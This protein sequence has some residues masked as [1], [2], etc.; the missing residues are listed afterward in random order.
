M[1]LPKGI[2][3]SSNRTCKEIIVNLCDRCLD[4]MKRKEY[5]RKLFGRDQ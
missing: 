1:K 4:D 5:T 3:E 2:G